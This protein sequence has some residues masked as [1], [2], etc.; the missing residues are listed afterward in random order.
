MK[1]ISGESPVKRRPRLRSPVHSQWRRP[2]AWWGHESL[3]RELETLLKRRV[4]RSDEVGFFFALNLGLTVGLTVLA[5]A[6]VYALRRRAAAEA[7]PMH[8][9]EMP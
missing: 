9:F 8:R 3:E 4:I 6:L 1:A 7:H 2:K 5:A